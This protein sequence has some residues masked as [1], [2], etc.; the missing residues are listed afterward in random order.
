MCGKNRALRHMRRA[1]RQTGI[2]LI[3]L[4]L[5][6]AI[7]SIG[8]VLV[9]R[10]F[11]SVVNGFNYARNK[12]IAVRF[13]DKKAVQTQKEFLSAQDT[14]DEQESFYENGRSFFYSRQLFSLFDN[15]EEVIEELKGA[16]FSVKWKEGNKEKEE[17]IVSYF[18]VYKSE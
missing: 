2:S 13:L 9:L 6:V 4:M 10:S 8:L 5:A 3:E 18:K 1:G 17:K 12:I 15:E 11:F 7:L 16:V 14:D